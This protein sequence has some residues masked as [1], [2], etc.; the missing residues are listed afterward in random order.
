MGIVLLKTYYPTVFEVAVDDPRT[1]AFVVGTAGE[2][3]NDVD[4]YLFV[5]DHP[6]DLTRHFYEMTD[7]LNYRYGPL[8]WVW[9]DENRDQEQVINDIK[10][11]RELDLATSGYWIDRPYAS[12]VNSFDF[13]ASQ[14]PEPQEMIDTIHAYGY[15]FALWHTPIS[16]EAAN[17][18]LKARHERMALSTKHR[19]F[20]ITSGDRFST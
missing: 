17:A 3:D 1:V 13:K 5:E 19:T 6:L 2:G 18:E 16:D 9:Q 12:G 14:F 7:G 20:S 15:R 4:F 8:V 11:M 10:T